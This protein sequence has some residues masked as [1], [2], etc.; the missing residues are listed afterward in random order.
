MAKM[1]RYQIEFIMKVVNEADDSINEYQSIA[2]DRGIGAVADYAETVKEI[3]CREVVRV[4][5]IA[6]QGTIEMI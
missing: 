5:R 3:D 6:D 1:R 4:H 2:T